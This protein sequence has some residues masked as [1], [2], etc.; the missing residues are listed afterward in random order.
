M[1]IKYILCNTE[2]HKNAENVDKSTIPGNGFYA[3][4]KNGGYVCN[5]AGQKTDAEKARRRT[6]C[7]SVSQQLVL[8]V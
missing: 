6:L 1:R 7:L 3:I 5:A 2:K 4:Y 8:F